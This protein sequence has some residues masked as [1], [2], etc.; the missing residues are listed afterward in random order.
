MSSSTITAVI[1]D[2]A[3]TLADHG[4]RA[5]VVAFVEAFR[6][7]GLVVSETEARGPMGT[8]KRDH[9]RA[10]L[11]LESVQQQFRAR[12]GRASTEDDVGAIYASFIPLQLA[13]L[14][15]HG[16][17]VPG[18]LDAV[19]ALRG[20]GVRIGTTTG[21]D[22]EMLEIVLEEARR[23]GLEPDASVCASDVPRGRPSPFMCWAAA[24]AL[25]AFPARAIVKVGD[26]IADIDEGRN[27]GMWSVGVVESGNELGLSAAALAALPDGERASRVREATA[28]MRE[29]GAHAVIP[30]V[31]ALPALIA[32]IEARIADGERP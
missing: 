15:D 23:Q 7:A 32:T 20:R 3:G 21:Y 4:S 30:S 18:A 28:R 26:T 1:F 19:R 9:V 24:T 5:P 6:R 13:V 27:A 11:T 2:W 14:R 8:A 25:G 31:A 22:R 16:A 10:L 17:L 12:A 29:A